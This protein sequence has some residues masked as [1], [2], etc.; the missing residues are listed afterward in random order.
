M[1]SRSTRPFKLAFWNALDQGVQLTAAQKQLG[2]IMR[3][4][5]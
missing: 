1:A 2:A 5:E 3:G 4:E